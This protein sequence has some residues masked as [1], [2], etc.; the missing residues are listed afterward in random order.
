MYIEEK[1]NDE[2]FIKL[3]SDISKKLNV[4]MQEDEVRRTEREITDEEIAG[5]IELILGGKNDSKSFYGRILESI[6][7]FPNN[8]LEIKFEQVP[9]KFKFRYNTTGRGK[10]YRV[11][12]Y[13]V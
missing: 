11:Q 1:I 8:V 3:K 4:L 5:R 12:L 10:N 13:V 6:I 7:V 9:G 2:E